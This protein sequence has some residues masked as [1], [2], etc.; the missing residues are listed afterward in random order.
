M[1]GA[2]ASA[3]ASAADSAA[4]VVD[5]DN[6]ISYLSG[7]GLDLL[8][9]V[10]AG[11]KTAATKRGRRFEDTKDF[12]DMPLLA[13]SLGEV[14]D[15]LRSPSASTGAEAVLASCFGP[16]GSDL[17]SA[18]PDDWSP[19][20]GDPDDDDDDNDVLL[21]RR[22]IHGCWPAL[23][24]RPLH[25]GGGGGG[26]TVLALPHKMFVPGSRFREQYYWDSYFVLQGLLA[27]RMG[28]SAL[29]LTE[30]LL[31]CVERYGF[32]PNG[33]RTY[34]LGRSQPPL[35]SE[36]VADLYRW[37]LD[38]E[39]DS[40]L[41]AGFLDGALPLLVREHEY[42]TKGDH[43]VR[44]GGR[45]LL[46]YNAGT[47]CP[48]PESYVEDREA[49]SS[50]GVYREI[51]TMAESGWD[52]SG[53]W[54]RD[55]KDLST[56]RATRVVPVD[57]NTIVARMEANVSLVAGA[58]GRED[59]RRE[60]ELLSGRRFDSIDEVLWDEGSGQWKD[61][62]LGE[63]EEEEEVPRRCTTY[64]SNWLPLWRDRGL[65]PGRAEA[66]VASLEASGL[67]L[68]GGL[69]TS[70]QRTGH[71]WDYPNAWAPLQYLV[72]EGLTSSG[73]SRGRD[74]ASKIAKNFLRN[75]HA[76]LASTGQM[77]E[78]YDAEIPGQYG[79]GGEYIPQTGFGWTN[80]VVLSFLCKHETML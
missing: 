43:L 29:Q 74:L 68:P 27:S 56:S 40:V 75:V 3:S 79:G 6:N 9:L 1:R 58:L 32:V 34:Y 53:R 33:T 13:S 39:D 14:V 18:A 38:N 7:L 49:T 20:G 41:P 11:P 12:V 17:E 23:C 64:A 76:T 62:V 80:G 47:T 28:T 72:H 8:D 67:V 15:R 61:L 42:W 57:L 54:L 46:R 77:H 45:E 37:S 36:M 21:L 65:P 31:H 25:P 22:H 66:A 2:E 5:N 51:A 55:S 44:V 50:P 69:A 70:V 24:K 48:R 10:H 52:F 19:A 4:V 26:T 73:G 71:Q 60:Y 63:E 16:P 59:V 78:K 30:N 35:L